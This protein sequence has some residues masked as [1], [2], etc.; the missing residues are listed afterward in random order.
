MR[1]S[2]KSFTPV[3][4]F[5][6]SL[7]TSG[8]QTNKLQAY[9]NRDQTLYKYSVPRRGK[10]VNQ[11]TIIFCK[12]KSSRGILQIALFHLEEFSQSI[13]KVCTCHTSIQYMLIKI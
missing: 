9:F 11:E 1:Q 5:C 7:L 3:L 12:R 6:C 10:L 2:T 4:L 8:A 13:P